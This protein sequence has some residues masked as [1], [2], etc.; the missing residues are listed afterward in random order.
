[1]ETKEYLI[2]PKELTFKIKNESHKIF[3]IDIRE[4]DNYNKGHI[5]GAVNYNK[6]DIKNIKKIISLDKELILYCSSGEKS[7]TFAYELRNAGYKVASLQGGWDYGWTPFY[8]SEG[9]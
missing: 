6:L 3:I 2:T 7:K 5:P 8:T 1:M 4:K 9:T